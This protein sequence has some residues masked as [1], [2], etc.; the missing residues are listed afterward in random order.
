MLTRSIA[1]ARYGYLSLRADRCT[2]ERRAL[3]DTDLHQ[4]ECA[5]SISAADKRQPRSFEVLGHLN[6]SKS[7]FAIPSQYRHIKVHV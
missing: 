4:H 5:Q 3:S 1:K 2:I 6:N 7:I